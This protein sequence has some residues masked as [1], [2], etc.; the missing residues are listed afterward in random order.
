MFAELTEE[1]K[2]YLGIFEELVAEI[3]LDFEWDTS[4]PELDEPW[5]HHMPEQLGFREMVA[6]LSGRPDATSYLYEL[7]ELAEYERTGM[8]PWADD[9]TALME[10]VA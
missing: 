5:P 2:V 7:S 9:V 6:W 4:L 3:S 1:P 10:A 8:V